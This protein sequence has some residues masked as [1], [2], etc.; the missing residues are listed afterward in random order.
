MST[1][2]PNNEAPNALSQDRQQTLLKLLQIEPDD[3]VGLVRA[4]GWGEPNT[5]MALLQLTVYQQVICRNFSGRKVYYAA[6]M[7]V[8]QGA[9]K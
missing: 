3:L 4:T 6:R 1:L 7:P 2:A 5:R 9:T 8:S